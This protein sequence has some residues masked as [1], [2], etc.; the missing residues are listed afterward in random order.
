MGYNFLLWAC[1]VILL[2]LWYLLLPIHFYE[3]NKEFSPMK[4]PIS[5]Y[6]RKQFE[7][8]CAMEYAQVY[9]TSSRNDNCGHTS[10]S[11]LARIGIYRIMNSTG[12]FQGG[13]HDYQLQDMMTKTGFLNPTT[14]TNNWELEKLI[15]EGKMRWFLLI[16]LNNNLKHYSC[17]QIARDG[18]VL[19]VKHVDPQITPVA[20]GFQANN[21]IG[22]ISWDPYPENKI[23]YA[24]RMLHFEYSIFR[25]FDNYICS[26]LQEEEEPMDWETV[27]VSFCKLNY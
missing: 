24:T 6:S 22:L 3:D 12:Y 20:V 1:I 7:K 16:T 13:L 25:K 15:P 26:G 9:N 21:L 5:N 19:K 18:N 11:F 2:F 17:C 4:R 23:N 10:I 27:D 8:T 14:V